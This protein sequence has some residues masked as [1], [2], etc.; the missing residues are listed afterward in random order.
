MATPRVS[1]GAN[2]RPMSGVR[3]RRKDA[4]RDDRCLHDLDARRRRQPD[5]QQERE[6]RLGAGQ[7][8]RVVGEVAVVGGR[9]RVS[10]TL[11]AGVVAPD[12]DQTIRFAVGQRLLRGH[13]GPRRR[14]RSS[15]RVR[16][17][18]RRPSPRRRAGFAAACATPA[19]RRRRRCPTT[20]PRAAAPSGA[21]AAATTADHGRRAPAPV[22]CRARHRRLAR[23]P[24]TITAAAPACRARACSASVIA[25][26]IG[27]PK[28]ARNR[29]G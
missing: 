29:A 15:R 22:Q 18:A 23:A 28:R 14:S 10:W 20:A 9:D 6:E 13:R 25:A 1:A 11:L 3:P 17:P 2:V 4:R 8:A 5:G 26:V 16:G 7:R 19:A 21:K 27:A 24:S 12:H